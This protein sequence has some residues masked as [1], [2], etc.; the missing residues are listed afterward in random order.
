MAPH[1]TDGALTNGQQKNKQVAIVTGS[2]R[3][4]GLAIVE[5]LADIW[6]GDIFLTS[7]DKDKGEKVLEVFHD[8]MEMYGFKDIR[9][10]VFLHVLDILDKSS[11]EGLRDRIVRG[12]G[13]LDI[14]INNA[15]RIYF[16][17]STEP[18]V[19]Q[20]RETIATNYYGNKWVLILICALCC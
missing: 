12:Y 4:I 13:G 11:I 6:D 17:D 19:K 7:R 8:L 14:L 18:Y 16:P 15:A 1:N 3:G 5:G 9:S 20:A 2:N 10:R